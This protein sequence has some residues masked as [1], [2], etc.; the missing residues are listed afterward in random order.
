MS[1]P[2]T[3][4]ASPVEAQR[5]LLVFW[6][7]RDATCAECATPLARGSLLRVENNQPLCLGCADLDHLD[8]LPS[9][10]TALTRRARK[11]SKLH[12]V[13]L[14][15]SRT[16]KRYERQGVLVEPDALHHAEEECLADADLRARRQLRASARRDEA[17]QAYIQQFAAAIT[18]TF[19]GCPEDEAHQIAGR[20]C[21]RASGRVGRTAAAKALDPQAIRAAV[22]AHVRHTHTEYGRLLDAL[23]D[24][25]L[26]RERVHD[27]V[28]AVLTR[29]QSA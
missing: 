23:A 16:R 11:Y 26:A 2:Q 9:G 20:A 14:E 17:D 27:Q 5:E 21:Q 3:S 6:V 25:A 12:A 22:V 15:W 1:S 29:W 19:P 8:Y 7:R 10:N 18:T 13:A 4:S 28:D 24:R